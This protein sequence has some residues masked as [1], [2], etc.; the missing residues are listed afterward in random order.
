MGCD[1]R[2]FMH[3]LGRTTVTLA[4]ASVRWRAA[5]WLAF[6]AVVGGIAVVYFE[7][8]PLQEMVQRFGGTPLRGLALAVD[9]WGGGGG[10]TVLGIATFAAGRRLRRPALVD[11]A[12]TLA[13]AGVWCWVLTKTGQL[14]LAERRPNDGGA[15]V[16]FAFDGHGV[17]G[18]AS[19]AGLLLWPVRRVLLG[20]GTSRRTRFLVTAG[21][22]AWAAFVGWSRVWLGMHFVWNVALG[23]AIGLVTGAAA[24][25]AANAPGQSAPARPKKTRAVA[26]PRGR[27]DLDVFRSG[28]ALPRASTSELQPIE[29]ARGGDE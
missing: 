18:H 26:P 12:L 4:T 21:L 24:A 15:M 13:A 20:R 10:L 16:L 11:T 3:L 14:V 29:D 27:V 22:V 25:R 8:W 1:L 2:A 19:G 9:A 6:V 7:K 5:Q 28:D 23:L 17:S